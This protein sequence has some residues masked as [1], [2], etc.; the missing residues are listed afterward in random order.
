MRRCKTTEGAT[1][2]VWCDCSAVASAKME[3][4]VA[5]EYTISLPLQIKWR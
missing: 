1:V 5:C 2:T 3:L 4:L